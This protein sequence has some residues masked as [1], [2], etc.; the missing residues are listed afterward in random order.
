MTLT[1][2]C[3]V[4]TEKYIKAHFSDIKKYANVVENHIDDKW[5]TLESVLDDNAQTLEDAIKYK[6]NYVLIDDKYE[7]E[8]LKFI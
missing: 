4:M 7:I 8:K 2:Y 5:C 6:V 1:Y 3:L